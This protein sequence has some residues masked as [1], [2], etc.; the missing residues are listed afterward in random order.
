MLLQNTKKS[1]KMKRYNKQG[2]LET[3]SAKMV[4]NLVDQLGEG[5][6]SGVS[7]YD[8]TNSDCEKQYRVVCGEIGSFEI[9]KSDGE[10]EYDLKQNDWVW[11]EGTVYRY[12]S[13]STTYGGY[14]YLPIEKAFDELS[15]HVLIK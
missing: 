12:H 2:N 15:I 8:T 13:L 14:P 9:C 4:F 5:N 6:H 3:I 10:E 7:I 11:V 1:N